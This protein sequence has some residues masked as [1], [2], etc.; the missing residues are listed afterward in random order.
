M[1]ESDGYVTGRLIQWALRPQAIPFN[2]PEYRELIDRYQERHD[3]RAL[4]REVASG[5][6]LTVLTVTD[7]GMFLGTEDGSVFALKPSSFR[8]GQTS[9]DDRLLDGLVQ[10]AIASAIYPKQRDLDE[11]VTDAKPPVT[12]E[13][14]DRVLRETYE[15]Y[16]RAATSEA[17]PE[18]SDMERGLVE[19]WR[20]YESRPAVSMTP[21]GRR[22][23][24]S[25]QGLIEKHLEQLVEYGCFTPD[26]QGKTVEYRPTL[27]Y[28]VLV[29]ELAAT[30]LYQRVKQLCEN[31]N[32]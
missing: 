14:V 8:T 3:F 29:R 1:A 27:R 7:R 15:A 16:K 19:A 6:G 10:V 24:N 25:T 21:Q 30:K 23:A 12:V 31:H 11:D 9:A 4:V 2:E 22:A 32:P 18:S 20:V 28:Q 5:L 13:D 26:R 17:D